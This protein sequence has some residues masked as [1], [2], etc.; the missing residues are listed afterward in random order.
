MYL[1]IFNIKEIIGRKT[2]KEA[3]HYKHIRLITSSQ[4]FNLG[5]RKEQNILK[6]EAAIMIVK[7]S[8]RTK[9]IEIIKHLQ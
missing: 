7:S 2:T 9:H 6:T 5:K 1:K 3:L 4:Y 8:A